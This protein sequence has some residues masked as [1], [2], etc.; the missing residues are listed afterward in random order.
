V[1][2]KAPRDERS[3]SVAV[4]PFELTVEDVPDPE[5]VGQLVAGLTAYNTSQAGPSNHRPLAVFLRVNGQIAGGADGYTHWQW[6]FV[7]H[8]W[9]DGTLRGNGAGRQVLAMMEDAARGRGA[10][11]PG[12]IRTA[13]RLA[14]FIRVSVISSSGNCAIIRPATPG[15]FSGSPWTA[16]G[17]P[18]LPHPVI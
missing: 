15:T 10:R 13:S 16:R 7:S 3:A 14:A 11:P 5:H 8:L 9:V 17:H 1:G 4:N 18:L 2:T 6:L 12:S